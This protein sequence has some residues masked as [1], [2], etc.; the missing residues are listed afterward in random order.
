ML[1]CTEVQITVAFSIV[2]FFY[3]L[4]EVEGVVCSLVYCHVFQVPIKLDKHIWS[5]QAHPQ[6]TSCCPT[7]GSFKI[8]TLMISS[9]TLHFQLQRT[10]MLCK[11]NI[12]L[13]CCQW[14]ICCMRPMFPM[15]LLM[16]L[17]TFARFLM[18]SLFG[19]VAAQDSSEEKKSSPTP[20]TNGV[21]HD[22][23]MLV[24]VLCGFKGEVKPK[25]KISP[26]VVFG[27]LSRVVLVRG[28]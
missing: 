15:C 25:M 20:A 21:S 10:C 19:L 3:L 4:R 23:F 22:G 1:L 7:R 13:S 17:R 2:L 18:Y 5:S 11:K 14:H 26:V 12:L 8:H 24:F 16:C 9:Q 28:S 27:V 6:S